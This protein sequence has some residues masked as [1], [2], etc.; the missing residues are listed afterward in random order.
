MPSGY[1][2][3]I[4]GLG[5]DGQMK[6][7]ETIPS[8]YFLYKDKSLFW[9]QGGDYNSS[10]TIV[11][12]AESHMNLEPVTISTKSLRPTVEINMHVSFEL[13]LPNN[14]INLVH[15]IVLLHR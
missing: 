5:T 6:K 9:P 11:L 3:K 2:V 15:R 1:L 12:A 7:W 4:V 14:N 13:C 10:V 8:I